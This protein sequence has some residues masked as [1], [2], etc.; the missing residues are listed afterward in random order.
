MYLSPFW[1]SAARLSG[2][3]DLSDLRA[4]LSR[5]GPPPSVAELTGAGMPVQLAARLYE[6][7]ALELDDSFLCLGDPAYPDDL[8]VLPHAPPVLFLRGD[9]DLLAPP[10]V[11]IVG[12][13]RCTQ[14]G[15]RLA[16]A[17]A[18]AVREAGGVVVS[19]LAHGIDQAAQAAVP[20]RTIAVLGQGLDRSLSAS[21]QRVAR[22]ILDAGGLLLSEFP[23]A[24]PAAR[25]TFPQRNR[26]I[27]GLCRATVV[28]EAGLRSGAL[29]TARHAAS[30]GREVLAVPGS[31]LSP[32]SQGCLELIA[33]GAT[34]LRRVSDV[35]AVLPA[36]RA[37]AALPSAPSAL[38]EGLSPTLARGLAE[39]ASLD[40][41]AQISGLDIASLS[42]TLTAL[43]L[44]G[45]VQRLPGDRFALTRGSG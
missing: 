36:A 18:Q 44:A 41:L 39:G 25:W 45:T 1:H 16:R 33:Q 17:L 30:S 8:A 4:R 5:P 22:R 38:P 24:T 28:V 14:T 6:A 40:R 37:S 15:Q 20:D 11:A 13:R 19:G 29:I 2:R 34:V 23:P 9:P 27:A 35:G 12:S 32:A 7:D 43:E 42:R 31:P 26:V 3:V 21:Q 10:K